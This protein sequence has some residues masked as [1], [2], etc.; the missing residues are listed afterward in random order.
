MKQYNAQLYYDLELNILSCLLQ[1]SE[2]MDQLQLEDKHFKKFYRFW[3]FMR[4]YYSKYKNFDLVMMTAL[5]KNKFQ[6]IEFLK[7]AVEVEPAPSRFQEYQRQLIDLYNQ[8]E[9]ETEQIEKIFDLANRL[10]VRDISLEEFKNKIE[11]IEV[12]Q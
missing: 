1:R 12:K 7:E 9:N 6:I 5:A 10:L 8:G 2:L 3:K 4:I 11:K